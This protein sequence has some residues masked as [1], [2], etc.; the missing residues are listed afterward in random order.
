M[1]AV[2][3]HKFKAIIKSY[4]K[5]IGKPDENLG[6]KATEPVKLH[7]ITCTVCLTV[8]FQCYFINVT[9]VILLEK[10]EKYE[11]QKNTKYM[12]YFGMCSSNRTYRL[13]ENS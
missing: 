5:E 1:K 12:S 4:N 11:N 10:R 9:I 6:L 2:S 13:W 3:L 8:F 7:E